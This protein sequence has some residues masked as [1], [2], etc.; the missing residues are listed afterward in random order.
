M[1]KFVAVAVISMVVAGTVWAVGN[2]VYSEEVQP[3]SRI[4]PVA[5][6]FTTT[7]GSS[8]GRALDLSRVDGYRVSVCAAGETLQATG[9]IKAALLNERSGEVM[10]NPSLDLTVTSATHCQVFPD[11]EVK[12]SYDKVMYYTSG[13]K[14]SDGG[15][16]IVQ[17]DGGL[18]ASVFTVR[19]HGF[20]TGR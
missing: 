18:D 4:K 1:K 15:T 7:S 6:D 12:S 11:Q 3:A 8:P 13:L 20:Y 5:S 19:I 2:E 17:T 14:I 16:L 9:T 10:D